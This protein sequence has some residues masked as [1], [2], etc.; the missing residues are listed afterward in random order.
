MFFSRILDHKN[1][2]N[3]YKSYIFLFLLTMPVNILAIEY[4]CD[5]TSPSV[6]TGSKVLSNIIS[7]QYLHSDYGGIVPELASREHI[8]NID[9]IVNDAIRQSKINPEEINLVCAEI[10]R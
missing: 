2:L 7:S 5:E 8:R 9:I 4:S 10:G 6:L 1:V 3:C